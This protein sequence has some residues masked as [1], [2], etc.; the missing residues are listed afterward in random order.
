VKETWSDDSNSS[1]S[2]EEKH[3]ANMC[4]MIIKSDNK[5]LSSDDEFDIIYNE[6]HDSFESLYDE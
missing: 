5:V 3:V 2:D 1:S 6:L 4:F